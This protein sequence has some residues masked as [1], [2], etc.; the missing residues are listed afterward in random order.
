MEAGIPVLAKVNPGNDLIKLILQYDV[1]VVTISDSLDDL[2]VAL[3]N[4]C[5]KIKTDKAI[6]SRCQELAK[7]LFSSDRAAE[8]ILDLFCPETKI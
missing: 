7:E 2:E 3:A 6:S 1:G 8:Q 5:N 4:L